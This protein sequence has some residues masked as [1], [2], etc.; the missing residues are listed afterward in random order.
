MDT[1]A[2]ALAGEIKPFYLG[3][4]IDIHVTT[5]H[6]VVSSGTGNISH[7]GSILRNS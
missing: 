2:R 4:A 5:T 6:C 3:D 1:H 7:V